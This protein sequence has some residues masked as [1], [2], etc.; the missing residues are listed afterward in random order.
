MTVFPRVLAIALLIPAMI[1]VLPVHL[2]S[3]PV[4]SVPTQN[5]IVIQADQMEASRSLS[6]VTFTGNVIVRD[7]T[8]TLFSESLQ[9]TYTDQKQISTITAA[10]S[11][12]IVQGE[13]IAYADRG[14]YNAQTRQAV[15]SGNAR[16][17]DGANVVSGDQI[18]LLLEQEMTIIDSGVNQRVRAV[19]PT[20]TPESAQ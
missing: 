2:F 4:T 6:Q 3:E 11:L 1:T 20:R 9:V 10:G 19:I 14:I 17:D 18:T 13:R 8:S 12:R 16:V 7:G 15:L 5:S